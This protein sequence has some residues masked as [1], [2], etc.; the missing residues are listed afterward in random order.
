MTEF[1]VG[2]KRNALAEDELIVAVTLT[3]SKTRQTFMKVGP[4]NAM[5]I[6]V[7]SLA[8]AVDRE[9]EEIRAAFGSAGPV[10]ALVTGSLDERAE[11]SGPGRRG[12]EPDRRRARNG[13]LS[14][15]RPQGPDGPRARA[16]ADV[17]IE[18]TVNGERREAD[19]WAGESLLF[20]LREQLGLPGSKN[21]CEQGECGSCSV[22]LDGTLVCCLPR[23]DRAGG[24]PR[25]RDRRGAG[26]GGPAA[27][28]AGGLRRD[29]APCSAASARP[30]WSWRRSRCSSSARIPSDD[31]IREA[32]SGNLCRCTGYQKIFD[33][34]R[35]AATAGTP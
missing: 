29:R 15:P 9:R 1:L 20:T 5:V 32:L 25:D 33:A 19:V 6:A 18:L 24:G 2:P 27:P 21:A 8:L 3:P 4:R 7:C 34:V 31:E 22:L 14:P 30:A 10:P 26:R 28:R 16:G 17:K 11:L 12:G 23:P 13:R 35:A